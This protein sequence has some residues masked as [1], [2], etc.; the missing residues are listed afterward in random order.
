MNVSGAAQAAATG[1]FLAHIPAFSALS[2]KQREGIADLCDLVSFRAGTRVCRADD[3]WQALYVVLS[4]QARLVDDRNPGEPV[5]LDTL[6]QGGFF[7]ERTVFYG[8]AGPCSV[9]GLGDL[10]LL[11]LSRE[12][13][14]AHLQRHPDV[15][16]IVS[17]SLS[18]EGARNFLSGSTMFSRSSPIS[19][20]PW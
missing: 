12:R 14:N 18:E 8:A 11:R 7:G 13:Y 19:C 16:K 20:R 1:D 10:T 4:G 3:D 2:A 9:Y 15:L 5:P 6:S 17:E